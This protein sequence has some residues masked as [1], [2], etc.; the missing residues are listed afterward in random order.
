MEKKTT[1]KSSRGDEKRQKKDLGV[2]EKRQK[3]KDLG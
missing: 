2:T 1:K 3:N